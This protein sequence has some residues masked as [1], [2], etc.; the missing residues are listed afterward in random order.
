M[1]FP[2]FSHFLVTGTEYNTS[3]EN[4]SFLLL[5]SLNL[6]KKRKYD[7]CNN[8]ITKVFSCICYNKNNYL[9]ARL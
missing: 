8:K 9:L 7:N 4:V 2:N 6:E 1:F 3:E 5:K